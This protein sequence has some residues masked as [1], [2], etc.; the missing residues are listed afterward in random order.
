METKIELSP[1]GQSMDFFEA[2]TERNKKR[3]KQSIII[4]ISMAI[5][6]T[7]VSFFKLESTYLM[8]IPPLGLLLTYFIFWKKLIQN[9]P[10]EIEVLFH[11]NIWLAYPLHKISL[12][13]IK[14]GEKIFRKDNHVYFEFFS[15]KEIIRSTIML[16]SDGKFIIQDTNKKDVSKLIFTFESK[17]KPKVILICFAAE[18]VDLNPIKIF[19]EDCM[20]ME[21]FY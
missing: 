16:V 14:K 10:H 20:K 13:I 5:V 7:V 15:K 3:N 19:L 18:G 9:G 6:V 1:W 8:V 17:G 2:S 4:M 21:V 12:P 11:E